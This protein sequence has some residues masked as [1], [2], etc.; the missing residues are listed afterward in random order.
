MATVEHRKLLAEQL[1]PLIGANATRLPFLSMAGHLY[2]NELMVVGRA[3]NGW[4][5]G[6]LPCDLASPTAATNYAATI[7]ESV[8]GT[9]PCPMSWVTDAW[10]NPDNTKYNTRKSAFW[11]VIR[12]VVAESGIADTDE[13]SWPSHLVW[14]NLYKVAPEEGGNPGGALRQIQLSHCIALLQQEIDVY[15]PRRLLLL[16]GLGWAEPFLGHIAPTFV[17]TPSGIYVEATG[18][19]S[20][21]SGHS[22]KIVV[23]AHPQGKSEGI[24]VREV[25]QAF[26]D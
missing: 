3:P 22:T 4:E 24:W 11:R 2:K 13:S 21:N 14:S 5:D 7:Y 8:V 15:L 6:M 12:G 18:E 25:I 26:Q 1:L 19:I 20:R 9:G 23:A 16:T 17:P 10:A